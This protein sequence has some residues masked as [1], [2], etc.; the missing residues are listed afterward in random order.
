MTTTET[1]S[2][3]ISDGPY[4]LSAPCPNCASQLRFPIELYLDLRMSGRNGTTVVPGMSK[5]ALEHRC[6]DDQPAMFEGNGQA[7]MTDQ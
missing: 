5:K 1:Q 3:E 2:T 7:P 4:L 6:G